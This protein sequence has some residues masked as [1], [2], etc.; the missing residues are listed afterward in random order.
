MNWEKVKGFCRRQTQK[1]SE[2]Y[3]NADRT[4]DEIAEES[5]VQVQT[6][7]S[8]AQSIMQK[9]ERI[10]FNTADTI[11][12][13]EG[14]KEDLKHLT[15][16]S[17]ATSASRLEMVALAMRKHQETAQANIA[18]SC[19]KLKTYIDEC[20]SIENIAADRKAK[21]L[22]YDFFRNKV[23]SLRANP[24]GDPA[25][26]PRNEIRVQEWQKLYEEANDRLKL[27]SHNLTVGGGKTLSEGVASATVELNKYYSETSLA[28]RSIYGASGAASAVLTAGQGAAS[29][30][31][32]GAAALPKLATPS[33][34]VPPVPAALRATSTAGP[35]QP[36]AQ[37]QP[38]VAPQAQPTPAAAT[39]E[40]PSDTASPASPLAAP[41]VAPA[42]ARPSRVRATG[43][44]DPFAM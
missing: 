2:Q 20:S 42:P 19:A 43:P 4:R 38:S 3:R 24:P 32:A 13:L 22:E 26:I 33:V 7:R 44:E 14:I 15:G 39:A 37:A 18:T 5:V 17:F 12:C 1:F 41:V 34:P 30:I 40:S 16:E 28:W 36:T 11:L 10:S 9:L 6:Y 31:A 23:A 29:A 25:R 8:T 21:K 35:T 27:L